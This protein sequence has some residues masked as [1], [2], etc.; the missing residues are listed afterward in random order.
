MLISWPS[1]FVFCVFNSLWPGRSWLS[2]RCGRR[3]AIAGT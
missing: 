2:F 3:L 1:L